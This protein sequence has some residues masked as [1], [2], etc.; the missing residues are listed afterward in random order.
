MSKHAIKDSSQDLMSKCLQE[1][2]PINNEF[3]TGSTSE[4][5]SQKKSN[6]PNE[7][8]PSPKATIVLQ[9]FVMDFF[10]QKHKER[11]SHLDLGVVC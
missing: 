4:G 6:I 7:N 5:S 8:W 11:Y 10:L 9:K 3:R 1:E 2:S